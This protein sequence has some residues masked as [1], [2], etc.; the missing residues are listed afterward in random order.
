MASKA[1]SSTGYHP[2]PP[3]RS[4]KKPLSLLAQFD[5]LVRNESA[6]SA[7]DEEGKIENLCSGFKLDGNQI[8]KAFAFSVRIDRCRFEK[9]MSYCQ[10]HHVFLWFSEVIN[11]LRGQESARKLWLA[12][13]E[14]HNKCDSRVKKLSS[15]RSAL[16][17]QLKHARS[18][19]TVILLLICVKN[20]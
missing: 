18:E 20:D 14:D 2:Q 12:M 15:E 10:Y 9:R 6:L 8:W 13:S 11:I 1:T 4:G 17:T 16:E 19:S 5:D 3:P 7:G